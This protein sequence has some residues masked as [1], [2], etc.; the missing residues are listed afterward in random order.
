[1]NFILST[2][3][4]KIRH[5][6]K[7]ALSFLS[8]VIFVFLLSMFFSKDILKTLSKL[9][10]TT[11]IETNEIPAEEGVEVFAI[12]EEHEPAELDKPVKWK[13]E[14]IVKNPAKEEVDNYE[15]DTGVPENVRNIIVKDEEGRVVQQDKSSWI[16][17]IPEEKEISYSIEYETPPPYKEEIVVKQFTPGETYKKKIF[18]K[19]DSDNH[20]QNV[21]AYTD[22][23]EELFQENYN[24]R[25]YRIIGFS[26][27]DVT[28]N[29]DYKVNFLD[30]DNDGLNDRIE[31]NV[32][33]LSEE[34]FEVKASINI[35]NVQSYPTVWGNWTVRFNTTGM[36]D[37][38]ITPMDNTN[39]DV[40]IQ[41]LELKCGNNKLDSVYDG[42]SIFYSNWS[43]SEEGTIINKILKEGK[44]TLE[45]RFGDDVEYAY[46]LA[47]LEKAMIAYRSN[48]GSYGLNSPKVKVWNNE[49]G[50]ENEIE[51]TSAGSPIR[52]IKLTFSPIS[53]K[54]TIV[55]QSDDGYIDVYV[56]N[57][58]ISWTYSSNIGYVGVTAQ[59]GFDVG[60]ETVAGDAI[61]V[62]S[63]VSTDA[64]RDLAYK[65]LS[66]DTLSFSGI[67]EQYINDD[68][69]T[70]D[71][72]YT[73]IALDRDTVST[74]EELIVAGFDST[75][76]DI[77]AWVWNGNS[78]GNRVEI[79]SS[80]TATSGYEALAV[81]Y[82]NDGSKGMVIG[83]DGT[84]GNVNGQY[85][86]GLSWTIANIGDLDTTDN[87]DTSWLTLKAD[88]STDD[89]MAVSVDSGSDLHTMYWNGASWS[90]TSNID[91]SV[92][93]NSRRCADF[94]WNPIGNTGILIWDT[95]ALSTRLS[96]RTCSPQCTSITSTTSTYAGSGA[97]IQAV[98]N[99][100]NE[101]NT[102]ILIGR[103]NSNFYIGSINRSSIAFSNY[104]DTAI[105]A[106]ATVTTYEAFDITFLLIEPVQSFNLL[107]PGLTPIE[108]SRIKPGT[109][110]TAL[111]FNASAKTDLNV[112]PCVYGYG[113]ALG[114]K[115][116]DATPIF[117]FT[118]TGNLAEGWNI[119]LS[120]SLPSYITLYGN[121]N[122]DRAD[123]TQI[124]TNG[125]LVSDNIPIG[126]SVQVWL[127]ADFIDALPGRVD[128]AINHTSTK[129]T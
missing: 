62:Y 18:V 120:Q 56:S 48:T 10:I 86:N 87:A 82:A 69:H 101:D 32:P 111:D 9:G 36:A 27:F 24:I 91:T 68:G 127:W 114:Y 2:I 57:D 102:K 1:M 81:K 128:I 108:S 67:S 75:D 44:H 15:V 103:L 4:E 124:T 83:A 117:T 73:W 63:V 106:A 29:P 93:T 118:N 52:F 41:F 47:T 45:F 53:S 100:R 6:N 65:V 92:D 64:S 8:I 121:T 38:T 85:W 112:V 46:N 40:D 26:K 94:A 70:N 16:T 54:R 96:Y 37:L 58:G 107:L 125:W 60:F 123:A 61:V 116:D 59:R 74:S 28:E 21:K 33:I 22:I 84:A 43:C 25:L 110:T 12:N 77:D 95:D 122:T 78:C 97:W 23:P 35:I 79:S 39:F 88:P 34:E 80:A 109:M 66:A 14:L 7:I 13:V 126:N 17:N 50:W 71:I 115:Q 19:S 30:S 11:E 76:R 31:W 49:T 119:S 89:L 113:C 90:I 42:K 55:T 3:K 105:T 20:Y 99:P 129:A 51:L 104:G 72:Q 98:T 5:M